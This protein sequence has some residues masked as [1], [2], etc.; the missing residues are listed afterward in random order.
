MVMP[1]SCWAWQGTRSAEGSSG[2]EEAQGM[3]D[4]GVAQNVSIPTG[5]IELFY[6]LQ[7]FLICHLP[8]AAEIVH[9]LC[10]N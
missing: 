8:R 5:V 7:H 6:L 10:I 1:S 4:S 3:P 9:Q 2:G